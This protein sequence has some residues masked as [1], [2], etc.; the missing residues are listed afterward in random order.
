MGERGLG[1]RKVLATVAYR[2]DSTLARVGNRECTA[3]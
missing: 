2:L 1:R 3:K